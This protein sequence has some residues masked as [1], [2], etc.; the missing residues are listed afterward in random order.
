MFKC[1]CLDLSETYIITFSF[2][3]VATG[4]TIAL[5]IEEV[6]R[7]IRPSK[8]S[9]GRKENAKWLLAVYPV[10]D[11]GSAIY[12]TI[13]LLWSPENYLQIFILRNIPL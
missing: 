9:D 11:T 1:W 4:V 12:T 2:L 7:I 8:E 5:Y 10:R 13:G 6:V 3:G